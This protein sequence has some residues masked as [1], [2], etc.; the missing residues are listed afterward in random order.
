[1]SE[2]TSS[3]ATEVAILGGGCFWCVEAV[4]EDLRGVVSVLPGYSGGHV[5]H[6]SYEQVCGKATGHVEVA[7]VEF[8]PSVLSYADLLRVF[9][10]THDPTTPGRQGNDVGPQYE[11]SI[12][13]QNEAQR[14]Q[15]QAV[16]AEVDAQHIYDAPIVTQLREPAT[17]WPAEDYHRNYFALHPEQGYCQFVI[18]P[19][20]AKFRKQFSDRLKKH[21]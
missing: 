20:V 9:F 4:L 10:A 7:R 8:D 17:F 2:S 13:W 11:S 19:K 18:A 16:I 21:S 12:F 14:Q 3:P 6:P 15:A 5:D 1:M